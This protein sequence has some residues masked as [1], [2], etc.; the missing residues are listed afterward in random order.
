MGS[1]AVQI[2]NDPASLFNPFP[3]QS[4]PA[5]VVI[6]SATPTLQSLPPTWTPTPLP[7]VQDTGLR[8]TSPP[9]STLA[10]Y[11]PSSTPTITPTLTETASLT[12]LVT[13]TPGIFDCKLT[14]QL[15][16]NGS[17]FS[18]GSDFF[19][20]WTVENIGWYSLSSDNFDYRYL[21]GTHFQKLKD[22][23]DL[24]K[25]L[26]RSGSIL[27]VV[28]MGAPTAPG[29]YAATWAVVAGKQVICSWT[30]QINVNS[31]VGTPPG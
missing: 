15:P 30:I 8:P 24:P 23:Y 22:A 25:T 16:P 3:P 12:P 10:P 14:N 7:Q 21:N 26:M 4:L 18:P 11:V 29:S 19:A 6:P 5:T 9:V 28:P 13:N 20:T 2:Y 1:I 31:P 27:L 17:N